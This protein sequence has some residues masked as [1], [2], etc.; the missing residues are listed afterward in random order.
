MPQSTAFFVGLDVH[1]DWI[2]A[3]VLEA[4]SDAPPLVTTLP[5]D[6]RKLRRLL[7]DVRRRGEVR[8]CYEASGG[9]FT[10]Q[11]QLASWGVP[12]D[13]IAPSLIPKRPGDRC[14]TDERDAKQL[15]L[16]HRAGL[17]TPVHVPGIEQE[18]ARDVVRCRDAVR[19]QLHRSRQQVLKF[20][21]TRGLIFREGKHWTQLHWRWLRGLEL[22]AH[23][24]EILQTHLVLLDAKA[25]QITRLDALIASIA[26]HESYRAAVGRLCCLRGV[27]TLTAMTLVT[28]IGDIRRFPTPAHLMS[29]VGLTPSE[30]SSGGPGNER[31]GKI[32][33]TGD[34]LCRFVLVE[35]AHH[36]RHRPLSSRDMRGRWQ[37]QLPEV[38]AHARRAQTRL[39][40]RFRKLSERM[41]HNLTAVAI[42]RELVGFV[43]AL[44]HDDPSKWLATKPR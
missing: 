6:E 38:V 4:A 3:A 17:L 18:Q 37:G 20:L 31:R 26:Q 44:M 12:C 32:T 41:H 9:G 14:K 24:Q 27:K 1:K 10:L 16:L 39:C 7:R 19:R 33:K 43:W 40:G 25:A 35:A 2:S 15:A 23:D 22:P 30:H 34:P 13:V 36:Y 42:A 21:R 11:R 5:A 29:Y 28:T 8:A